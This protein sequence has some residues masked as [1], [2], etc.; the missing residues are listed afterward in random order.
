[1]I[2]NILITLLILFMLQSIVVFYWKPVVST[3]QNQWQ[4]NVIKAQRF[5]Y[6][7]N[8]RFEKVIVGSSLSCRMAAY[9][10]PENYYN[11]AFAGQGV[12]E[13]LNILSRIKAKPKIVLVEMN[14]VLRPENKEF[15]GSL[16][17][18]VLYT[19]KRVLPAF[20][21]QNQPIGILGGVLRGASKQ[22]NSPNTK[23]NNDFFLKMLQREIKDYSQLPD[24][25]VVAMR[26]EELRGYVTTLE[27][28][29]VKVI[30]FEM[31]VNEQLC[32][33][34]LAEDIRKSFHSYFPA[35]RY[36]YISIPD[37]SQYST[38]DG[39]HLAEKEALIYSE[40]LKTEAEKISQRYPE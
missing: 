27:N 6:E 38:T 1:M 4:D 31:P 22:E 28:Q 2:K 14:E 16:F 36:S 18:P 39:L 32:N 34:P 25:A 19:V 10:F 23:I 5:I 35:T 21:E 13:G 12:F 8:R 20:R 17:A 24:R 3:G 37:C 9:R 11:L 29:G 15:T 33:L 26:F 40:Y 30:F 7:G